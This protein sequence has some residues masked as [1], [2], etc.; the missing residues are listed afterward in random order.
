MKSAYTPLGPPPPVAVAPVPAP[1]VTTITLTG[2]L[3]VDA[4][5]LPDADDPD[6]AP[7]LHAAAAAAGYSVLE[8]FSATHNHKNYTRFCVYM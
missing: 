7:S 4:W 8:G 2:V 3:L 6:T 1:P 5:S